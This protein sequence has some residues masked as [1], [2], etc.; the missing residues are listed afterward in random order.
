MRNAKL[1]WLPQIKT[2][3]CKGRLIVRQRYKL[4]GRNVNKYFCLTHYNNV[5]SF[6]RMTFAERLKQARKHAKLS[7][8]ALA[9]KAGVTQQ[10]ISNIEQG[11][12]EKSTDV[13]QLAIACGVRPEWL[14]IEEGEM[15]A[16]YKYPVPANSPEGT[17]LAL[18]ERMDDKTKYQLIKIGDTLAEPEGNGG[19]KPKSPPAAA[20][21]TK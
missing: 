17:V 19:D 3:S 7:Q 2:A 9:D 10:T 14:A 16:A 15:V 8:I 20:R 12:Q 13:V 18:M 21:A 5:C 4:I 1:D 6:A 11:I